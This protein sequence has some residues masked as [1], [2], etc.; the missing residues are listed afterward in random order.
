MHLFLFG[1]FAPPKKFTRAW[2]PAL[3]W[4]QSRT[5]TGTVPLSRFACDM[6]ILCQRCS[7]Y[8]AIVTLGQSLLVARIVR[9]IDL[10]RKRAQ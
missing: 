4:N 10:L 9:R 7:R 1:W 3:L 2:E 8:A 6:A 5:L